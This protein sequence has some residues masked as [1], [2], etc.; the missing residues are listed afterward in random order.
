M[1]I[2]ATA[3]HPE[4]KLAKAYNGIMERLHEDDWICFI[5]HDAVWTTYTWYVQILDYIKKYPEA[6]LFVARTNRIGQP[7]QVPNAV[8]GKPGYSIPGN[9][10][11]MRDHRDFGR[12][13]QTTYYLD[14]IDRTSRVTSGVVIV[15]SKQ[16]WKKAGGFNEKR[17]DLGGCDTDYHRR[18][19]PIGKK[20]YIMKG[21]YVYHW[22]RESE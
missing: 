10:H 1:L 8:R 11:D 21:V 5:D 3:Y 4:R 19:R 15:T 2:T 18:M 17:E 14:V 22:Y 12:A 16:T 20:V 13:Q 9:S 6:G 7:T